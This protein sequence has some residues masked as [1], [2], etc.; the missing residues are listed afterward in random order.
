MSIITNGHEVVYSM[1]KNSLS[2]YILRVLDNSNS[3][4]NMLTT[5]YHCARGKNGSMNIQKLFHS[6]YY[7]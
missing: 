3:S 1:F 6:F 5:N 4:S 7:I 2:L